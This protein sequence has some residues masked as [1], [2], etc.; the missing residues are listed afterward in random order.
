MHLLALYQPGARSKV[1]IKQ[2]TLC[3]Y[4]SYARKEVQP[5]LSDEAADQLIQEYV[6]LRKVGA[7]VSSDPTRRVITATPRQLESLVR[8]SEA[9][10]RMRLSPIVEP[11]DVD[12]AT[13][14]MRVAT[15]SAATDPVTGTIDMDLITTGRSAAARTL[16]AQLAEALAEKVRVGW[17]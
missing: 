13:R 2:K 12:E 16:T 15:Q 4:I 17:G 5:R 1:G 11:M 7:S 9:H 6:A 10:A 14:L 8:L 3:D